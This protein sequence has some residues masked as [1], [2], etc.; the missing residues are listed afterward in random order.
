[1]LELLAKDPSAR[2]RSAAELLAV[3]ARS[4]DSQWWQRRVTATNSSMT[5][6]QSQITRIDET[7]GED[8]IALAARIHGREEELVTALH[9][10]D[11]AADGYGG[12]RSH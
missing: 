4:E 11:E 5:G 12:F 7:G 1:M 10:F 8:A 6:S 3:L 9:T 2:F